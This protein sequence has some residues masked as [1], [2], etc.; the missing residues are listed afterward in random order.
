[1]VSANEKSECVQTVEHVAT[2]DT[3]TVD[4]VF[5]ERIE[6]ARKH[7]EQL[8]I[9]RAKLEALGMKDYPYREIIG[10]LET[11]LY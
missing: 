2:R 11:Y 4:E 6:Q 1:M 8:C 10:L 3:L 5:A 9:K 7:L